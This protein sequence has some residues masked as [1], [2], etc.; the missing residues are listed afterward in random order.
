MKM[1]NFKKCKVQVILIHT[2][3]YWNILVRPSTNIIHKRASCESPSILFPTPTS[4]HCTLDLF[5]ARSVLLQGTLLNCQTTKVWL[6]APKYK[7]KQ[8]MYHYVLVCTGMQYV[9][10]CQQLL[11]WNVPD[12]L[13][14]TWCLR[15]LSYL[16][17]ILTYIPV[18]ISTDKY[19]PYLLQY[20]VKCAIFIPPCALLST[21]HVHT[22][23]YSFVLSCP[24][25]Q[26]SNENA[27]ELQQNWYVLVCTGKKVFYGSSMDILLQVR[28]LYTW[29]RLYKEVHTGMCT[30]HTEKSSRLYIPVGLLQHSSTN[31]IAC[32]RDLSIQSISLLQF[33][34]SMNTSTFKFQYIPVCTNTY[35]NV[36]VCTG[37][38]TSVTFSQN[39]HTSLY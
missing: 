9:L 6:A 15:V 11:V 17:Y 21:Y 13:W 1:P 5:L 38:Y 33:Y 36:P 35:L 12:L 29:T 28:I 26:N 16:L 32:S 27:I 18:H 23:M 24:G 7:V 19:I 20:V 39:K 3:T 22:S 31:C 10:M 4:L 14:S 30:V 37:T 2:V 34:F 8:S 25:V